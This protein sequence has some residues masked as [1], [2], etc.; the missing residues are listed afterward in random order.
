MTFLVDE[1][2]SPHLVQQL[3]ARGHAAEHVAHVGKAAWRDVDLWGHA[4][5]RSQVVVTTNYG[6]FL[7]LAR[8]VELH[9]GLIVFRRG[10]LDRDEQWRWL[11]PVVELLEEEPEGSLVNQVVE[12][13]GEGTF[14]RRDFPKAT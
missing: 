8:G 3:N 1:N 12:V 7:R 6:D 4:F 13:L 14:V 2:L 11:L 10:G 9:P 5:D